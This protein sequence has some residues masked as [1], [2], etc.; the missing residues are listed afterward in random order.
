MGQS[1]IHF[2]AVN[3]SYLGHNKDKPS[4]RNDR[5]GKHSTDNISLRYSDVSTPTRPRTS[6][7]GRSINSHPVVAPKSQRTKSTREEFVLHLVITTV[8]VALGHKATLLLHLVKT[9][10]EC[11][12]LCTKTTMC[13]KNVRKIASVIDFLSGASLAL[14]LAIPTP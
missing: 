1:S 7:M 9:C 14:S 13:T 2:F 12:H 6:P 10:I 8:L 11:G 3:I 4:T 5:L